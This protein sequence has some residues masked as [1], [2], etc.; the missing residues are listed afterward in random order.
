MKR[1]TYQEKAVGRDWVGAVEKG[2]VEIGW[3]ETVQLQRAKQRC[4]IESMK[5]DT[6]LVI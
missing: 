5:T 1:A 6:P 4:N 2:V 3:V